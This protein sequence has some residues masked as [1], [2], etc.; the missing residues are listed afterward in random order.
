MIKKISHIILAFVVLVTSV[1]MTV[2]SHYCGSTLESV[3]IIIAPDQCCDNLD[4]CCHDES[5]TIKIEDNFSVP[6]YSYD[7]S[8]LAISLP[9][10]LE[11][12]QREVIQEV[13]FPIFC[14]ATPPPKI[15][16]AISFLQTFIL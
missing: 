2:S 8:Q 7:F 13:L 14:T 1:G 15:Q 11:L 16:T 3:S 5:F 10:L 9:A 12:I 4:G 6:S